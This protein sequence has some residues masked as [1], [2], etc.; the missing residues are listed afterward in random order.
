MK[1]K[2]FGC[3]F[4][5]ATKR[6]NM[7]S[8]LLFLLQGLFTTAEEEDWGAWDLEWICLHSSLIISCAML[9][10]FLYLSEPR[11]HPVKNR[12]N[13]TFSPL[14]F[15]GKN[16]E[17]FVFSKQ[18]MLDRKGWFLTFIFLLILNCNE[19]FLYVGYLLLSSF[20]NIASLCTF[21]TEQGT[22]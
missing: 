7:E 8:A 18:Q 17:M 11:F 16:T 14:M 4:W 6:Q 1:V 21:I 15:L 22:R 10:K 5:W 19:L 9:A 13:D 12:M 2:G 20:L 3:Q